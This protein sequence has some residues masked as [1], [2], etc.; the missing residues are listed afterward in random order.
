MF[1]FIFLTGGKLRHFL[2]FEILRACLVCVI[3]NSNSIHLFIFKLCILIVHTLKM[4]TTHFMHISWIFFS[5]LGGL[6][7]R[8]FFDRNAKMVSGLC[9][10]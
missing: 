6:E 7:L 1:F 9:Y 8:H 4:C 3:C 10:L 5:F 2:T